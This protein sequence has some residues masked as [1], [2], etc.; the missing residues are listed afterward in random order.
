MSLFASKGESWQ[1][2]IC[3]PSA[4]ESPVAGRGRE[5]RE[6][7]DEVGYEAVELPAL[8]EE[9]GVQLG[10]GRFAVVLPPWPVA[11]VPRHLAPPPR[12]HHHPPVAALHVEPP[13]VEVLPTQ[14][15][16]NSLNR[17]TISVTKIFKNVFRS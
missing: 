12:R 8:G 10:L 1:L 17:L 5:G 7:L 9:G 16:V 11:R 4:T 2:P 3:F 6:R 13:A 14:L 15:S